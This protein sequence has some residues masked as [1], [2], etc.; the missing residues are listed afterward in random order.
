MWQ[1]QKIETV[2]Q[3]RLIQERGEAEGQEKYA[4]YLDARRQLLEQVLEEIRTIE[5]AL[6]DHGPRHIANVLKNAELL[7][8]DEISKL[9]ATELYC[10][11][12]SILF[13]D[14]GNIAGREDHQ[15]KIG[16][17]YDFIRPRVESHRPEKLI[18]LQVVRAH[19]G[20]AGDDSRD[21]LKFLEPT[22]LDGRPVNLRPIAAIL[23]FADE[24]AEGPQRTSLFMQS[25]GYPAESQIY[26]EYAK[27]TEVCINR[28]GQRIALTYSLTATLKDDGSLANES[29]LKTLLEYI[30]KR[31][32]KLDQERKYARH[33]CPLLDA[34][35]EVSVVLTLWVNSEPINLGL[36]PLILTDL[37]VP[38]DTHKNI[39]EYDKAYSVN[40]LL[41]T[42]RKSLLK[43]TKA[44]SSASFLKKML[45]M[46]TKE[47]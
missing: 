22:H 10:L 35:K 37:V 21:T 2:L 32:L 38:G 43:S 11:V 8:G 42:V 46:F 3:S 29:E 4:L 14:V 6:T 40:N 7:I 39:S 34:F 13:H 26:H 25:V 18:V 47:T 28:I 30:Y 15:H 1:T 23:R 33:Y 17:I 9:Q 19:C 16:A 12:L 27:V 36:K 45:G 24:L 31:I 5:P 20:K 44:T 41:E